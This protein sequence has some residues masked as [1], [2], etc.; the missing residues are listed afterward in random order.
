MN[1]SEIIVMLDSGAGVR[2][3]EARGVL[4]VTVFAPPSFNSTCQVGSYESSARA[5]W[6]IHRHLVAI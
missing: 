2:I 1:H 3:R 4:D 5:Y 6:G